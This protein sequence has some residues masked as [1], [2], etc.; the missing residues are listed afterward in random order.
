MPLSEV[1][2]TV[3]KVDILVAMNEVEYV[4][5]EMDDYKVAIVAS[6]ALEELTVHLNME[7]TSH[8]SPTTSNMNSGM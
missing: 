7:L 6:E 3:E 8:I 4:E 5:E 1:T 2:T